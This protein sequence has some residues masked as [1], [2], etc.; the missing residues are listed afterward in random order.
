MLLF[1]HFLS[2]DKSMNWLY[3]SLL[4]PRGWEYTILVQY[5][6]VLDYLSKMKWLNPW[7]A[8]CRELPPGRPC[9]WSGH[10][11]L[12]RHWLAA[13]MSELSSLLLSLHDY[14]W[15]RLGLFHPYTSDW[16]AQVHVGLNLHAAAAV[17]IL[18]KVLRV[19][20]LSNLVSTRLLQNILYLIITAIIS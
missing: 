3:T 5:V 2:I 7:I 4:V 11:V 13:W 14:L 6:T 1:I 9:F 16:G 15:L 8:E 17:C 20:A 19:S 12:Q 18:V 10:L